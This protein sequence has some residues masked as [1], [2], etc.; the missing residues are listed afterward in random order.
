MSNDGRG[1]FRKEATLAVHPVAHSITAIDY[2]ADGDL[3]LYSCDYGSDNE[4][5]GDNVAPLPWHDANNGAPNVLFRN[6][7][8]WKFTDVTREVGLDHNNRKYSFAASWEDFDNDEDFDL[9]VANDFG[10]KNLYRNDGSTGIASGTPGRNDGESTG[11]A[12]GTPRSTGTQGSTG[13]ASGTPGSTQFRDVAREIGADDL[14]PGMSAAWADYNNDGWMDLYVGNMFSGAG[15]RI[16]YQERFK[17]GSGEV[18][19]DYRRF[20]RGNTLLKNRGDGTFEDVSVGAGVTVGRWAWSS[21]F[22]DIN[23]DGWQDLFV[24]N[25]YVTGDN[26]DDL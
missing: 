20:A 11:I 25:G 14:G 1:R 5:F 8:G 4:Q 7:G 16:T 19:G 15:N 17:P 24:A 3:D 9:Y 21:L 10:R 22:V 6:D 13:K 26:P 2:D 12:S 18:V 23:N